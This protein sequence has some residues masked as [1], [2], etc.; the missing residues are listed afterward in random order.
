MIVMRGVRIMPGAPARTIRVAAAR[1]GPAARQ[2]IGRAAGQ[3]LALDR[4]R[5]EELGRYLTVGRRSP[6]AGR[7]RSCGRAAGPWW[8]RRPVPRGIAS[9]AL[10]DRRVVGSLPPA[11]VLVAG[12][13]R[14]V[15]VHGRRRGR[16]RRGRARSSPSRL[17]LRPFLEDRADGERARQ[18]VRL[19]VGQGARSRRRVGEAAVSV[20]GPIG[21]LVP[22][23]LERDEGARRGSI[24]TGQATVRHPGDDTGAAPEP[25]RV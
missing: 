1:D 13:R 22:I 24:R 11:D 6:G 15:G 3:A 19:L 21:P 14:I 23:V 5:G 10:F 2:A 20:V 16:L 8:R 7:P 25:T 12:L 18:A 9:G 4:T 17:T